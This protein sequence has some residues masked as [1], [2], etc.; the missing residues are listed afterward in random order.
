MFLDTDILTYQLSLLPTFWKQNIRLL[1]N[2]FVLDPSVCA[3]FQK[4]ENNE[5]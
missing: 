5:N 3:M 2:F 1:A 4:A